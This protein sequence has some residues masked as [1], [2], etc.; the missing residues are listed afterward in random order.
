MVNNMDTRKINFRF[1]EKEMDTLD[2]FKQSGIPYSQTVKKALEEYYQRHN[3][4]FRKSQR[5]SSAPVRDPEES[6]HERDEQ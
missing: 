4:E 1:S 3:S 5:A 6:Y 2:F